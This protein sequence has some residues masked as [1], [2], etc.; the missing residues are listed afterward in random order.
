MGYINEE[1]GMKDISGVDSDKIKKDVVERIFPKLP[2]PK[3]A[4][5][6]AMNNELSMKNMSAIQHGMMDGSR[7]IVNMDLLQKRL[8]NPLD[9]AGAPVVI[10]TREHYKIYNC[11]KNM[12]HCIKSM[13][14]TRGDEGEKIGTNRPLENTICVAVHHLDDKTYGGLCVLREWGATDMAAV[15]VGYNP[16]QNKIW[17]D[18]IDDIPDTLFTACILGSKPLGK[19]EPGWAEG[20]YEVVDGFNKFPQSQPLPTEEFN[21]IFE[22][23]NPTGVSL[24][25]LDAQRSICAYN[26]LRALA[27]AYNTNKKVFVWED[28]GYL[29]PIIDQA[30]ED[31][32]TLEQFREKYMVPSDSA[33]DKILKGSFMEAL[34]KCFAGSVE[35]TR[36]GYDM[37]AAIA[38][39]REM[40]TKLFSI[41]ASYEKIMLEG[42]SITLACLDALSQVLYSTGYSLRNRNVL[43]LGARGNLG[44]LCVKH[45]ANI[46]ESSKEQLWGCDLKVEWQK[47][48]PDSIPK[49]AEWS[50][51]DVPLEDVAGEVAA[52]KNLPEEIRYNLEVIFGWTGGPR[53]VIKDG[54]TIHYQTIEGQD[55]ADWLTYGKEKANLYL[56]SGSTKTVEF[57]DVL[58]WLETILNKDAGERKI[59]GILLDDFIAAPIPDQL[60][61]AAVAQ[62]WPDQNPPAEIKRNF[63]TQFTFIFKQ[64]D[65]QVTKNLYLVNNTMPINFMYYGTP[66]EIMD[67]TYSQVTSCAAALLKNADTV[68]GIYPTDYS[69]K[70]TDGVY[71]GRKLDKEYHIP[72]SI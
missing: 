38:E 22:G 28:G 10:H 30:I 36:N 54:K 3:L 59:N 47:P 40:N 12:P 42:D 4:A 7:N 45:L 61:I 50:A 21:E 33:V 69:K 2:I 13:E 17:R 56:V 23:K 66:T 43:I 6:L 35:L 51:C 20:I 63:G 64:D 46:L 55:V 11:L 8:E 52:Y 29:N 72:P 65:V 57:S 48:E 62:V 26:F 34:Q 9:S 44:R 27:R 68:P 41:A 25:F 32:L 70:A 60:S 31:K 37:N 53:T 71:L 19:G 14:T 67:M 15:F 58:L 16:L 39:T 18:M 49:W 5:A 1:N 24:T